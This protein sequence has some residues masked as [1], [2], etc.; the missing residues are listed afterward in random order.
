LFLLVPASLAQTFKYTKLQYPAAFAT[1]ANGISANGQIVGAYQTDSTCNPLYLPVPN[2]KTHGF[3]YKGSFK[4]YDVPGSISTDITGVN[5]SGDIVGVFSTPDSNVHGFILKHNGMLHR[6]DKKNQLNLTTVPM[7]VNNS[8]VVAGMLYSI[9]GQNPSS[10]FMWSKGKF[11]VTGSS[12]DGGY[13]GIS[14]DGVVV[15]QVFQSDF[16]DGYL[17]L[18]SDRDIFGFH[19]DTYFSGVND[20]ADI[21]RV[22]GQN[23]YFAEHVGEKAADGRPL[24][25]GFI[26][27]RFPRSG[28]TYANAI[29]INDAIVGS[30]NYT[31]G[32]CACGFLAVRQK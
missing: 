21:V 30:W 13:R 24:A 29:N 3:R 11:T 28:F 25:L 17:K 27:V 31:G 18:G 26:R 23:S 15:G 16:W 1:F 7:G 2:C 22:T 19:A 32:G 14:N 5:D 12:F 8:L 9:F 20:H 6:L 4:S 10:G